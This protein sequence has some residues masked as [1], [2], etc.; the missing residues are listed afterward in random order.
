M[1]SV[2]DYLRKTCLRWV[3]EKPIKNE[4][5]SH[6]LEEAL[7]KL[8]DKHLWYL[9]IPRFKRKYESPCHLES[10]SF[11][12]LKNINLWKHTKFMQIIDSS[13][14]DKQAAILM[15]TCLKPEISKQL[16]MNNIL[17]DTFFDNS[18]D[19][20]KEEINSKSDTLLNLI[21]DLISFK[22]LEDFKKINTAQSNW[23]KITDLENLNLIAADVQIKADEYLSNFAYK[24]LKDFLRIQNLEDENPTFGFYFS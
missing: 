11:E 13:I 3:S 12:E 6:T 16:S 8:I 15:I 23:L 21:E 14:L 22:D 17:E 19:L 24:N 18:I 5:E 10:N 7:D 9:P 2:H 4:N 20:I 1:L